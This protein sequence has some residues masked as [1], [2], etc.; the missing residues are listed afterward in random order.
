[1]VHVEPSGAAQQLFLLEELARRRV[2]AARLLLE[3]FREIA[4]EVG[5]PPR[6]DSPLWAALAGVSVTAAAFSDPGPP[7][8]RDGAAEV[9]G[10][11]STSATTVEEQ[12]RQLREVVEER[13]NPDAP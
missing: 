9:R 2:D 8:R 12:L 5:L 4:V 3:G 6:P 7:D 10:E 13:L 1:L 11:R